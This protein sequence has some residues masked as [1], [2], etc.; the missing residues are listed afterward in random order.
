M[1]QTKV[2]NTQLNDTSPAN[3]IKIFQW[4]C[5]G[6]G[7]IYNLTTSEVN[8][9]LEHDI[10]IMYETWLV[11]EVKSDIFKNYMSIS[12]NATKEKSKGRASG[13]VIIMINR[14]LIRNESDLKIIDKCH[15][16][17]F[18]EL[19]NF[20]NCIIIGA[21]YIS[22]GKNDEVCIELFEESLVSVTERSENAHIY[23][24][25]D[26]NARVGELNQLNQ[27]RG[28]ENNPLAC[29]NLDIVRRSS[30][31]KVTKRGTLLTEVMEASGMLLINGRSFSDSPAQFTSVHTNGKSVIDLLWVNS[32]IWD[33]ILDFL[34]MNKFS[35]SDHFP[36]SLILKTNAMR[37]TNHGIQ[38]KINASWEITRIKW[39]KEKTKLFNE[40]LKLKLQNFK[41]NERE[42]G[43]QDQETLTRG[44]KEVAAEIGLQQVVKRGGSTATGRNLWFDQECKVQ[45]RLVNKAARTM[46]NTNFDQTHVKIF[47]VEKKKYKALIK[48]KKRIAT[49]K[50]KT[51]IG[52]V[53]NS[54]E[55]WKTVKK[56]KGF[57]K[58]TNPIAVDTWEQYLQN[59]YG[60]E[61]SS[62][63]DFYDAR[64]PIL[65]RDIDKKELDMILQKLKTNKTPGSDGIAYEFF[66]NL[67]SEVGKPA[68]LQ[69]LNK[70]MN[71]SSIPDAWGEI[72]LSLI[73]KKGD[74]QN[75]DNYRGIAL[76][77]SITKI[78]TYIIA[79]RISNFAE[80]N[81]LI[82]ESQAGFREKRGCQDNIFT[83]T[84]LIQIQN[85]KK[86]KSYLIFVDFKKAF[87]TVNH[88]LL[89]KKLYKLGVS[90]NIIR[91]VRNLYK[92]ANIVVD[93]EGQLSKPVKINKGVLQGDPL[94][95][96]AF[97]LFIADIETQLRKHVNGIKI[98]PLADILM[99][100]YADDLVIF[101]DSPGD[102]Q[103]KLNLL[104]EYCLENDLIVNVLKT[105]ILICQRGRKPKFRPKFKYGEDE[106]EIVNSYVYLGVKFF[107]NGL[108]AQQAHDAVASANISAGT[109]R[110]ILG[111]AKNDSFESVI[112]LWNAI[113]STSLLYASEIWAL[114]YINQLETAQCKFLKGTLQ[115]QKCT[116]HYIIRAEANVE[117]LET[118]VIA[119]A[120]IWLLKI[121]NMPKTRY[122]KL[123]LDKLIE[124]DKSRM[125]NIKHNWVTQLKL[126]L[127]TANNQALLY[128]DLSL[129]ETKIKAATILADLR[130][131]L[132]N[133]DLSK[134]GNS[135]FTPLYKQIST[136]NSHAEQQA[137]YLNYRINFKQKRVFSQLRTHNEK[138]L[139]IGINQCWYKVNI[140]EQCP[141][142]NLCRLEKLEHILFECP[143][144]TSV[145]NFYFKNVPSSMSILKK[146]A[147]IEHISALYMFLSS[148]M[149]IRSFILNE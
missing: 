130:I 99:L 52:N 23:I 145:R 121:G 79:N 34:V 92:I 141:I 124:L 53:K 91:I 22:P 134:I 90:S 43:V 72:K 102:A 45:K 63:T 7:N 62:E 100:A 16:W 88:N 18:L 106:I 58:H 81:N 14:D 15:M 26:F 114:R 115:L 35:V 59:F 20:A 2:V 93:L 54:K 135:S 40:Q 125:N 28:D 4:N 9:I 139:K 84:S 101:A 89:W 31:K 37:K 70:I 25:G 138:Y 56:L 78:L 136:A 30:D 143:M 118:R 13:G 117:K 66:K 97:I 41:E 12:C 64:H 71:G 1:Q 39:D 75:P 68:L 38:N 42:N 133:D 61:I 49:N 98:T 85:F 96:L 129:A 32:Q 47:L 122:P 112:T 87:D 67:D 77:N 137:N 57:K 109:L 119:R 86:R 21:V 29:T 120:L 132:I 128:E 6:W 83:L 131:K 17:I 126:I 51:E 123:C 44:I 74:P 36:C 110:Q 76:I 140:K 10:I 33:L 103:R 142:C 27:L 107:S 19:K 127:G 82:P 149:K 80:E 95:A 105:K 24:L 116:P 11:N 113:T 48:N 50:L 147:K 8:E 94:S 5:Q 69:T 55:F 46:R 3:P 65:D 146:S 108:F 104:R 73:F 60:S 144:Y 111:K 148:A